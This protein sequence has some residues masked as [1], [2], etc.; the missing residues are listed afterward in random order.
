MY[1]GGKGC[2]IFL[3]ITKTQDL[4]EK[5]VNNEKINSKFYTSKYDNSACHYIHSGKLDIQ[6]LN[7]ILYIQISACID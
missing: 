1:S 6:F 4:L 5:F 2:E 7:V 3:R